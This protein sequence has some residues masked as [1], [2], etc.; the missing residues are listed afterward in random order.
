MRSLHAGQVGG[1]FCV[2]AL[3][4]LSMWL[5]NAS[6]AAAL[7]VQSARLDFRADGAGDK[8]TIRGKLGMFPESIENLPSVKVDE[9]R[10]TITGSWSGSNDVESTKRRSLAAVTWAPLGREERSKWKRPRS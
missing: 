7:D 9:R 8:F 4:V 10:C 6:T 5:M 1:A 3:L 2:R